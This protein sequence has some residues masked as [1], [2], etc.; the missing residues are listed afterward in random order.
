MTFFEQWNNP[1]ASDVDTEAV[2]ALAVKNAIDTDAE[3]PKSLRNE[4]CCG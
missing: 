4:S 3:P 2:E 1:R